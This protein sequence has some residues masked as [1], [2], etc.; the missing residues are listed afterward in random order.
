MSESLRWPIRR[1]SQKHHALLTG[2]AEK[3]IEQTEKI[4]QARNRGALSTE[5][6]K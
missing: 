3:T 1:S 4:N 2:L 6:M 5:Q